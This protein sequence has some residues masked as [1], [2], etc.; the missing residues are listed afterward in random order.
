V[1]KLEWKDF[2]LHRLKTT[3]AL[4]EV[5]VQHLKAISTL[6]EVDV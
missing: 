3:S 2:E 5:D 4:S 6:S 1:S